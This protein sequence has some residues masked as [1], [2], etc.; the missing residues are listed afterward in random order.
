M[1][2]VFSVL[3]LLMIA[4]QASAQT[5]TVEDLPPP[6]PQKVIALT[7]DD[8]PNPMT[9]P[10]VLD[11]LKK[12]NIKATFFLIGIHARDY[13]ELVKR[14]DKNGFEIGN[15]TWN[16][17]YLPKCGNAKICDQLIRTS[18][19]I[20]RLTGKKP[21]I[22]HPPKWS[23][24]D[25]RSIAQ[26]RKCGLHST[27]WTVDP[28]DWSDRNTAHISAHVL[29]RTG[30]GDIILLHDIYPTTV[31]AVPT[32]LDGLIAQGFK[33]VTVSELLKIDQELAAAGKLEWREKAERQFP[34]LI[35]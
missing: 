30:A 8:G 13:P 18:E 34:G 14:M 6:A 28:S 1:K 9:T 27:L 20:E 31:A 26:T 23:G 33:F 16:H 3:M 10:Q 7:F 32:I 5:V 24:Y 4:V 29:S 25:K 15:H 22:M 21:S 35:K 11:E 12:R 17:P 19:L 2:H